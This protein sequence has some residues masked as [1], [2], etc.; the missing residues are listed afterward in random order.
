MRL[1]LLAVLLFAGVPARAGF[2]DS[3]FNPRGTAMGGAMTAV[4]DD[5]SAVVYNP[6]LLGSIRRTQASLN[7]LRQFQTPTGP[8]NADIMALGAGIPV[9]QDIFNGT[10]GLS[11]LY[12]QRQSAGVDR[13]VGFSYGTRG[14][15]EFDQGGLDLGGTL[16]LLSRTPDGAKGVLQGTIDLGASYRFWEKYT[17]GFSIL[18]FTRPKVPDGRAPLTAKLGVSE[19]VR[20]F[21]VALDLT[22]RE[23]TGEGPGT[24]TAAAGLER[25]WATARYGS[26]AGRTGLSLG[27]RSKTW[28]WGLGWRMLGGELGY[29]MTVP[30]QG[31]TMVG[32]GVGL[33]F[34]FGASNPEGEYEK[35]LGE[36]LRQRKDLIAAL[37]AA[38]VKQWKLSQELAELRAA[39]EDLRRQLV[40]RTLSE[41]EVKKRLAELQER[42]RRAVEEHERMLD[43]QRRLRAKTR[44]DFFK[45]DWAAYGKA[46]A[47][48]APDPVLAD[49]VRRILRDY[50]DSGVDLSE[51]NQELLRLLRAR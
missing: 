49:Q 1:A 35:L 50:K 10:F 46:R 11:W 12:G 40:E 8:T 34:R 47:G 9:Q 48:G 4:P 33:L 30:M 18:N 21:T 38:E 36:E 15:K 17:A 7:Y 5:L 25:W 26:F 2:E 14:L 43:E 24:V 23:P 51:A 31:P 44:L 22:K 45:E 41:A 6:A 3:G 39:M 27:D 42:H 28:N 13:R 19:A 32:H 29:A 16:K 37:E 20:G